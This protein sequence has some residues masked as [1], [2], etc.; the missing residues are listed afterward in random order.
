MIILIGD[1]SY[2]VQILTYPVELYVIFS[3]TIVFLLNVIFK[4]NQYCVDMRNLS[5]GAILGA[6]SLLLSFMLI[7]MLFSL[8]VVNYYLNFHWGLCFVILFVKL[9]ISWDLL[10]GLFIKFVWIKL[11]TEFWNM[12]LLP[13]LE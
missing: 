3:S 6:I 9:L 11:Y 8:F 7:L 5:N 4:Q 12:H 2:Y 10:C 13:D 1:F